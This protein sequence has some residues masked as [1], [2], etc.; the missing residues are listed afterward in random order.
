MTPPQ[1]PKVDKPISKPS[2]SAVRVAS[3]PEGKGW[4]LG[5]IG[6]RTWRVLRGRCELAPEQVPL[7]EEPI[8]DEQR[9][10]LIHDADVLLNR[11]KTDV[12]VQGHVYPSSGRTPFDFGVQVKSQ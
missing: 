5:V 12:V 11:R 9:A 8:Y 2:V 3:D 7:V 6:K 10:V 1:Q 4:R